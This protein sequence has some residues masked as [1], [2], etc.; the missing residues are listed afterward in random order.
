MTARHEAARLL[1]LLQDQ[2]EIERRPLE[3]IEEDLRLLGLDPAAATARTK[4]LTAGA[5]SAAGILMAKIA[6]A[7]E[8]ENEIEEIGSASIEE[9]RAR[10]QEMTGAGAGRGRVNGAAVPISRGAV[11]LRRGPRRASAAARGSR[12]P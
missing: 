8:A 10:L 4:R 3:E 9:V 1:A 12:P 2:S 7:E 11:R 5:G 6:E